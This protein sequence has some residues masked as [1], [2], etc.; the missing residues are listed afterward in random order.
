MSFYRLGSNCHL[1]FQP[2]LTYKSYV[3]GFVIALAVADLNKDANFDLVVVDG[4]S[5]NLDTLFG[6]MDGTFGEQATHSTGDGSSLVAVA[7]DD[8][9][10][11]YK[12]SS[13]GPQ[14]TFSTDSVFLAEAVVI[15]HFNEDDHLDLAMGATGVCL[16]LGDGTGGFTAPRKIPFIV[17]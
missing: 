4:R 3:S 7:V 16:M 17:R 1:T 5:N 9:L 15:G 13:V 8:V 2:T 6:N 12:N 10:L 14:R 11:G